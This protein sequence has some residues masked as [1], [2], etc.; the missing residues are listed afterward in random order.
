MITTPE[1]AAL[2]V[3]VTLLAL[4]GLISR[5]RA[6]LKLKHRYGGIIDADRERDRVIGERDAL[7]AEITS[8]RTAWETDYTAAIRELEELSR[9]LD[10]ARDR[11]ELQSFGIYEPHYDFETSAGFKGRLDEIRAR[12]KLSTI[13]EN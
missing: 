6:L 8:R 12:Q 3:V 2:A 9:E 5:W 1:V 11:A 4:A 10:T 7:A 13:I